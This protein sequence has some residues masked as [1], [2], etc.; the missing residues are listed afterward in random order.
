MRH[1]F[2]SNQLDAGTPV[3]VVQQMAAHRSLAVTALY[4]HGTDEAR[5]AAAGRVQIGVTVDPLAAVLPPNLPPRVKI[6]AAK[7]ARNP[8]KT[9]GEVAV[10]RD[11]IEPPTRGFSIPADGIKY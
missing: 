9:K 1:S 8:K 6:A 3:H 2:V 5:R 10:P 11:G 4:S 7:K